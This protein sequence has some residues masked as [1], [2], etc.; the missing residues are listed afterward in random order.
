ML[1]NRSAI[2]KKRDERYG[3][4]CKL[5]MGGTVNLIACKGEGRDGMSVRLAQIA[6]QA[7]SEP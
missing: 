2:D 4:V 7:G 3:D 5:E 6:L 1:S